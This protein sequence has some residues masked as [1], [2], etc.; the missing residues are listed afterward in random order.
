MATQSLN[1]E[2]VERLLLGALCTGPLTLENR[3]DTLRRLADHNWIHPD[4]RV[5]YEALRRS[6]QRHSAALREHIVAEITR[7]GFPDIEVEPF[8][9]PC[10]LTKAEI[11]GLANT[12][13]SAGPDLARQK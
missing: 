2:E 6:R 12:L 10:T 9:N 7:L 5:I 4:H 1:T 8:F 11:A 13:L 3:T